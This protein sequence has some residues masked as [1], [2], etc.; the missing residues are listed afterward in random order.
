MKRLNEFLL[1][2][3]RI[4]LMK[5]AFHVVMYTY[6]FY[7]CFKHRHTH[8]FFLPSWLR[9]SFENDKQIRFVSTIIKQYSIPRFDFLRLR[10]FISQTYLITCFV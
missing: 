1:E 9:A 8:T 6:F 3:F 7:I 10:G 2:M 4:I 5:R